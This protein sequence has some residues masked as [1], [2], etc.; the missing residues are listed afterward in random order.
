MFKPT[1]GGCSVALAARCLR[2]RYILLA[3]FLTVSVIFPTTCEFFESQDFHI[4]VF[5]V[6]WLSHFWQVLSGRTEFQAKRMA[7]AAMQYTLQY[8]A[9][10]RGGGHPGLCNS[11]DC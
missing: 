6:Y 9:C 1:L 8:S 3:S 11:V 5:S 2:D 4:S 7:G 10:L